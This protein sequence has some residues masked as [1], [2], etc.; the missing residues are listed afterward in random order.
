M[1]FLSKI[2]GGGESKTS[3]STVWGPQADYLTRLYGAG[4]TYGGQASEYALNQLPGLMGAGMGS[5]GQLGMLGQVGN[6][7]VMGQIGQLGSQL[8][9]FYNEQ[10]L[11]GLS[12]RFGTAGQSAG[13]PRQYAL[14]LQAGGLLGR[15]FTTGATNLLADSTRQAIGANALIP[16]Q[17]AALQGLGLNAFLGPY[18][19]LAS[20][21][22]T[23]PTVLGGGSSQ[24]GSGLFGSL[25]GAA[26]AGLGYAFGGPIGGALAGSILGPPRPGG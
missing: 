2:F 23:G 1:G 25:L 13:N 3:P 8:G 7:F 16:G 10:I 19:G 20:I 18:Q 4:Q 26:G 22:G 21:L 12:S 24:S 17:A 14:A 15:E 9:Q 6:P 5:L 11:P